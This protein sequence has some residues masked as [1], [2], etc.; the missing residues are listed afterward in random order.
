VYQA[1]V[2]ELHEEFDIEI[3]LVGSENEFSE[4]NIKAMPLPV[5]IHKI[6]YEHRSR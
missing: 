2:R 6:R 3:T 1:L 5:S 4:R